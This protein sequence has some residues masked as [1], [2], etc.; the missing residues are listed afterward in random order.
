MAA[1][2]VLDVVMEIA[3]ERPSDVEWCP[4]CNAWTLWRYSSG[5]HYCAG[6]PDSDEHG[7]GA[8]NNTPELHTLEH[9]RDLAREALGMEP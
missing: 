8:W 2:T 4:T 7:C 3:K 6:P 1:P 5:D 9:F